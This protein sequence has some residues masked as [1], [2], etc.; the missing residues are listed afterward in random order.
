MKRHIF[1][2]LLLVS[3]SLLPCTAQDDSLKWDFS[4]IFQG[5][6][7][8]PSLPSSLEG[9]KDHLELFGRNIPQEEVFLHMD[10][11]QATRFTSKPTSVG[12]TQAGSRT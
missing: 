4:D 12:A 9:W 2:F 3:C 5:T 10:N 6:K 11:S 8:S 1:L 7:E